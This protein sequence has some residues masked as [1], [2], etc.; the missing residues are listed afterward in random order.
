MS[1]AGGRKGEDVRS[2]RTARASPIKA[3]RIRRS[4]LGLRFGCATALALLA[5]GRVL[6]AQPTPGQ[7][8]PPSLQPPPSNPPGQAPTLRQ[9][10]IS[11]APPGAE[12]T[13]VQVSQVE[14]EGGFGPVQAE[15]ASLV[16]PFANRRVSVA[17]LYD[18]AAQIEAAYARHGYV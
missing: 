11:R 18:L 12:T 10:M 14:V 16:T 13:F 6:A 2:A 3:R 1:E 5:A 4:R 15:T 17:Q 9:P 8:T 7:V